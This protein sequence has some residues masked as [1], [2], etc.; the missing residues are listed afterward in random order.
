MLD[1]DY[2]SHY[3]EL[4]ESITWDIELPTGMSGFFAESGIAQELDPEKRGT[5]RRIVRMK[6]LMTIENALPMIQREHRFVGVYTK[7]FSKDGCGLISPIQWFPEE[8]VRLVLPTFWL[9]LRVSC[10]RKLGD[11]CFHIGLQLLNRRNPERA[12]F[13]QAGKFLRS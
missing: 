5:Q 12:A 13:I 9:T 11:N 10:C 2:P 4:I 3:A 6:G 1:F 8:T 7:D